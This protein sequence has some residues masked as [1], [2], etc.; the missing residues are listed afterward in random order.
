MVDRDEE[1]EESKDLTL[2][3]LPV[4]T[5]VSLVVFVA[6]GT[7]KLTTEKYMLE[8]RLE[9]MA[10]V[11]DVLTRSTKD[12]VQL[13]SVKVQEGWTVSDMAEWCQTQ[14]SKY[15]DLV[16]PASWKKADNSKL[17]SLEKKLDTTLENVMQESAGEAHVKQ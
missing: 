13:L 16:C 7:F 9:K 17:N 11:L 2:M 4:I 1:G 3:T 15:P 5:T 12:V 8:N 10:A 6:W 14:K